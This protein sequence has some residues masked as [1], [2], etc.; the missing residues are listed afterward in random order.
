M[1]R[2]EILP[3][4]LRPPVFSYPTV[5]DFSG[6]FLLRSACDTTVVNRR[7]GVTGLYFFIAMTF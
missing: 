4:L 6:A 2:E 3:L 5:S 7:D 1:N